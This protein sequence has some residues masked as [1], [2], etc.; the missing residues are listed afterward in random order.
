MIFNSS[1]DGYPRTERTQIEKNH[2]TN[3]KMQYSFCSKISLY[4]SFFV[5]GR[6]SDNLMTSRMTFCSKNIETV[7]LFYCNFDSISFC[8]LTTSVLIRD[9]NFKTTST[10]LSVVSF[11][12]YS[13]KI[14]SSQEY[15]D[16]YVWDCDQSS[17][18]KF[19]DFSAKFCRSP[20]QNVE[21]F[22]FN[23]YD[24]SE[25]WTNEIITIP[26]FKSH[27]TLL[28]TALDRECF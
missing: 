12:V 28:E 6:H 4:Y 16:K 27:F 18:M 7:P 22:L 24:L 23:R 19:S 5:L 17:W 9:C 1:S 25:F 3:F 10:F 14:S 21:K 26:R 15:D 20:V 2:A 13:T 8:V 11:K